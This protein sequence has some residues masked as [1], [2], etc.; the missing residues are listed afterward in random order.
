MIWQM[1]NMRKY[2]RRDESNR[3]ISD[4]DCAWRD[5]L[6]RW[7]RVRHRDILYPADRLTSEDV[8]RD[9]HQVGRALSHPARQIGVPLRAEGDV[10]TDVIALPRQ[11]FL[12]VAADAVE[13]LELEAR[14]GDVV[15]RG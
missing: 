10:D 7:R 2:H 8:A 5:R 1:V 6:Y 14:A 4:E 13:H 9:K 11:F 15:R 3:L 12:Q